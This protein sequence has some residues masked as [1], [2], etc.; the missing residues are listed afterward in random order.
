MH[1]NPPEWFIPRSYPVAE[2]LFKVKS[3]VPV[4]PARAESRSVAKS[5]SNF[6]AAMQGNR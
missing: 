3:T 6:L 5:F 2:K 4:M 1:S